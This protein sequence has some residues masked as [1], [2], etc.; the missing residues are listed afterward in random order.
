VACRCANDIQEREKKSSA[1]SGRSY[2]NPIKRT[3]AQRRRKNYIQHNKRKNFAL[4]GRERGSSVKRRRGSRQSSTTRRGEKKGGT[5]YLSPTERRKGIDS[6]TFWKGVD[7]G[8]KTLQGGAAGTC[9][10]RGKENVGYRDACETR[11]GVLWPPGRRGFRSDLKALTRIERRVDNTFPKRGELLSIRGKTLRVLTI[12]F[13]R[14][15]LS[16]LGRRRTR[17]YGVKKKLKSFD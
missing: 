9:N 2:L 11:V 1:S 17:F 15:G 14:R 10:C 16:L 3:S 5:G 4:K 7:S 6:T 12:K 13:P 8:E